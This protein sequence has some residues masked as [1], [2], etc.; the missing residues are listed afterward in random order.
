LPPAPPAVATANDQVIPGGD[1]AGDRID[2]VVDKLD[3]K[4]LLV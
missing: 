1:M 2:H 4:P 3:R